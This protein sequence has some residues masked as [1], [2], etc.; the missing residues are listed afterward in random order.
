[1]STMSPAR[2]RYEAKL[3]YARTLD[4]KAANAESK[5]GRDKLLRRAKAVRRN[6]V[7]EWNADR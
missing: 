5:E 4:A 3:K 2:K 7:D 1:M 6:A